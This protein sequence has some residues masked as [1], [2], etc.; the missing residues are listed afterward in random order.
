MNDIRAG[1][2]ILEK[3]D[4]TGGDVSLNDNR[5][6]YAGPQDDDRTVP[7]DAAHELEKL[8][9]DFDSQVGRWCIRP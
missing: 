5:T 3:Y 7:A 9:W 6:L 2:D 1:F 8:G 4:D